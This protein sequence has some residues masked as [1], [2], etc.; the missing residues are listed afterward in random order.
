MSEASRAHRSIVNGMVSVL[1]YLFL[2]LSSFL[3][4]GVFMRE[5]GL[6]MVGVDG[7]FQSMV[8]LLS[9]VELGLSA[10]ILYKIYGPIAR[11]DTEKIAVLLRFYRRA[12]LAVGGAL[13][14]SG[15]ILSCFVWVFVKEP[16]DRGM[17][18]V[19]FL[20]Y[21]FDVLCSYL[22]AHRRAMLT[23][24]QRNY[25]NNIVH[26]A[27]QGLACALQI[28]VLVFWRSLLWYLVI[29][30]LLRLSESV[31]IAV[32]YQRRYGAWIPLKSKEALPNGE[33]RALFKNIRAMLLHRVSGF[34]AQSA[35][36]LILSRGLSLA[37]VGIYSSYT[38]ITNGLITLT[39]QLFS[40]V[41]ASFGALLAT[42]NK[43]RITK[44][45]F[46]LF[47]LNHLLYSFLASALISLLP[48]FVAL[49]LG[50]EAVLPL[51]TTALFVL[52][53]YLSG[54]R[55]TVYLARVSAG[56]YRPDRY[57]AVM[58]AALYIA[59]SVALVGP[60]GIDGILLAG[61]LSV[62][63]VPFWV[64]PRLVCKK[65]L[66]QGAGPYF[67]R[68]A[69]YFLLTAISAGATL[70]LCRAL[71]ARGGAERLIINGLAAFAVPNGVNL[72]LFWR[73]PEL[74]YLKGEAAG[75]LSK[76]IHK[77]RNEL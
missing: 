71:P 29:K 39:N 58:E 43:E 66:G 22:F 77:G 1:S 69:L 55:Q 19:L 74:R 17:L 37:A 62:L 48:A 76:I 11:R 40:G 31:I 53:F 50:E 61:I 3:T 49:W 70:L 73:S 24:D 52:Y 26:A 42:K 16:F 13:L 36:G 59:L 20:F 15:L 64:Q 47:F 67:K 54:M 5:L 6:T 30:V 34:C 21:V 25:I 14:T 63:L 4:R 32:C 33:K 27:C 12:Y 46:S 51:S 68:Y 10:G 35:A 28:A 23:A 18:A 72:L 38:M 2:M 7:L 8:S 65:V 75:F 41:T 45:F 9:V 60:M 44:R 57:F 56:V